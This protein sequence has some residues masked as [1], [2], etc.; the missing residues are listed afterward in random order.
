MLDHS[1]CSLHNKRDIKAIIVWK[2][3]LPY[4]VLTPVKTFNGYSV[5]FFLE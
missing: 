1:A 2:M 3:I 4:P 5:N